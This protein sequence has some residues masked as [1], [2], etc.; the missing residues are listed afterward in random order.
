[1][2]SAAVGSTS[3]VLCFPTMYTTE[4]IREIRYTLNTVVTMATCHILFCVGL[5]A[6]EGRERTLHWPSCGDTKEVNTQRY[7]ENH[8]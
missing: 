1:M 3:P 7:Y 5:P 6:S 2:L 4:Y 8:P